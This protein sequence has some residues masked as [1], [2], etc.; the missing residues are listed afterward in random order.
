MN[1]NI[2][3]HIL[4]ASDIFNEKKHKILNLKR[5]M[6][7]WSDW[8]LLKT[9]NRELLFAPDRTKILMLLVTI[10]LFFNG[11]F[12]NKKTEQEDKT[13]KATS[14]AMNAATTEDKTDIDEIENERIKSGDQSLSTIFSVKNKI[15][16]IRYQYTHGQPGYALK[17]AEGVMALIKPDSRQRLEL[18]FL[19]ARCCD[20]L[21]DQKSRKH[22]D[23]EFR[24]LLEKL[25]KSKEHQENLKAGKNFRKLVDMSIKKAEPLREKSVFDNDDELFNL[26]C[27]RK[28]KRANTNKVLEEELDDG[29][30]IFYGKSADNVIEAAATAIGLLEQ[31]IVI[32][33][34]PRF[35][36]YFT[37]IEGN[38]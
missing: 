7:D 4:G 10:A 14:P 17:Q 29:G 11:C 24:K 36:F 28:L 33:K 25:A 20:Q 2:L 32:Q 38:Q 23:S 1:N 31:D 9:T 21:G 12:W 5:Y 18:H 26:R 19:M 13:V 6:Q 30:K 15:T 34:D 37:I 22:H 8:L 3:N 27:F 16:E 35:N